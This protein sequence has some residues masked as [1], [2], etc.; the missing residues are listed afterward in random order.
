[1]PRLSENTSWTVRVVRVAALTSIIGLAAGCS[2]DSDESLQDEYCQAGEDLK[3]DIT[4]LG[5]LDLVA[6]GTDGLDSALSAVDDDLTA[7]ADSA[8]SAAEDEV[9]A[10]KDS[11]G[12]LETAVSDLGGELTAANASAVSGA[13]KGVIDSASAVYDTLSDC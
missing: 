6:E 12:D 1:M 3:S 11:V 9:D 5:S 13:V 4:S 8:S 2:S 10:L 7:L